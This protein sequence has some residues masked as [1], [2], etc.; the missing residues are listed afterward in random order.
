MGMERR[1]VSRFVRVGPYKTHYIEW[2]DGEPVVMIHGG[3]PGASGEFGW[4]NTIGAIGQYGRGIALDLIGFGLS[5]KPTDIEYSFQT[6]VNHLAAFLDVLCLEKVSLMGNSM[7]AYVAAKYA[8]D[9]P[10]RVK[11]MLLV[12]SGTIATAMGLEW[13]ITPGFR[14]LLEYDGTKEGL[15]RFLQGIMH[16]PERITEE[17]LEERYRQAQ[18]PGVMEVQRSFLNYVQRRRKEPD[19]VQLFDLRH[20]L[21]H[22]TIPILF[23]WGKH[24]IFASVELAEQLQ[25]LLPNTRFVLFEDSG[26]V[27][28]ND[29]PERFNQLA[30]DFFF[31]ERS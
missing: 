23:V 30:V 7:G 27:V 6:F 20:R 14:Q 17:Q 8:L 25:K 10:D 12:S 13:G 16:H 3:G 15:R 1:Y 19:Q 26:H 5:D 21:P 24:D 28:Q 18:L 9:Y 11:K 2:G 22:L 29:E 31:G 4:G